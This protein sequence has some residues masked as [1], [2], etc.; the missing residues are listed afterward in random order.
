MRRNSLAIALLAALVTAPSAYAADTA[1]TAPQAHDPDHEPVDLSAVHVRASVLPGTAEDLA[2]P[3]EVLAGERLDAAKASSL[4]ETVNK[5]PGVQSSY[6]GPG[7]GRPIV[8]GFDGARVQVLSDGLGSGDVSTVSA[9][10]AVSIEPFLANQIEV[11]KG[12]STLLYGSGAIGGAV[13]VIDGRIPE[14]V[15]TEPLQGRAELRAGTVNDEKTGMLR[16]DGTSASGDLVF[17]FDALHRETG[18]YAIPG[19]AESAR[20]LAAEGETPEP[21]S[22]GT[23]ANS[24]LR[25][26]SAALGL[27]WI[28]ERGF[29]G[30][31]YSLFNTRYGVPGHSH[32][33][34]D[35]DGHGHDAADDHDHGEDA[36][37]DDAVHILMDQRRTEVRAGLDGLGVF[38]TLR[39]KF[40]DTRY[41][42][43]EFEG[44]AIGTVFDNASKEAR[45]E[46]VHQ[47]WA[48]WRG[49]FGVQWANRTFDAAGEEAFVPGTEGNDTG[50][51]WI[52]ERRSGDFKFELGARHDRNTIDAVPQPLAP[53]RSNSRKFEAISGSAAVQWE[54]ND[55]FHA[56][57]GLDRSQRVPTAEELFSNG[58]HVATGTM[59]IGDDTLGVETANR[60]ELGV[61]WHGER[62]DLGAAI[63]GIRYADFIYQASPTSLDNPGNPLMD[64]GVPVRLWNQADARF[65]GMEADA[66]IALV[67][68]D[69]GAWDLRVF[70]D[71][72]RGKLAD[73]VE[74][75]VDVGVFHGEHV[76]R[77]AAQISER[78]N[79]PRLAPSRL[80]SE[81][82]WSNGAWRASLGAVR[83]LK[84]DRVAANETVTPGY[85]LVDAHLAWHRDT[86]SGNAWEVF[87]DGS[88]LLDREARPHTSFLKDLAPLP[89][90]GIAFGVRAFF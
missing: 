77:H 81:L 66:T 40:A 30:V 58:L 15:T 89:G 76:H 85:T 29:A 73:G 18:D 44:A 13:N 82:S 54:L 19:F 84:Q 38:E 9:D 86:P 42:H 74:R 35:G 23:L 46:L 47:P 69:H 78:G 80:G 11:L 41:T 36:P 62:I 63:Y 67:D 50:L 17:H 43:T 61:R 71:I 59:E 88:N 52:G 26:D 45:L 53:L 60:L 65:H 57:L 34:G 4:G 55:R 5:L 24:A 25:T 10:H 22:S 28:G 48:G 12:P 49:A 21:G 3:V 64:D 51:F 75:D 31:G 27:S 7:V 32:G 33:D 37:G 14:T 39:F 8:R 72:V 87:L 68:N 70:G 6:F 79:L 1:A 56:S 83:Y 20:Q 90:R 2:R 16:L